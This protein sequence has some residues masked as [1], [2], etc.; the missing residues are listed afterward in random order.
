M[1]NEIEVK[2]LISDIIKKVR[3]IL[4]LNNLAPTI[5]KTI[6]KEY[7]TGLRNAEVDFDLNFVRN[8]VRLDF[9]KNYTFNLIK[10]MNDDIA[11]NLRA[12]LSRAIMNNESLTKIKERVAKVMDIGMVRAATIARTETSR[13]Q[14]QGYFDSAKQARMKFKKA[15][16]HID[17]RTSAICR[18]LNGKIIPI[19]S[20]FKYKGDEWMLPPFHVNCRT[21]AIYAETEE[22]LE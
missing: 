4:D 5:S 15:S 6:T 10:G 7:D 9:L 14:N 12:E 8:T 11:A 18:A 3:E 19:N 21:R 16:A 20:K 2:G 22:E 17:N 1:N 13:A